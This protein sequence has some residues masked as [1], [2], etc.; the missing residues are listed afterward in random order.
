MKQSVTI[1][2][3]VLPDSAKKEL[4][5]FYEYL[6]HKYSTKTDMDKVSAVKKIPGVRSAQKTFFKKID[7]FSFD[8]PKDYQFERDSLYRG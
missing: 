5:E 3:D 7:S 8:L 6:L 2:I 4:S 1:R